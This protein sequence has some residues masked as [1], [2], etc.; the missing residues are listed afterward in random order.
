WKHAHL[1]PFPNVGELAR[2]RVPAS[3]IE[4][5]KRLKSLRGRLERARRGAEN[6]AD[7]DLSVPLLPLTQLRE[8]KPRLVVRS[9]GQFRSSFWLWT[10]PFFAAFAAVHAVWR[11]R[12]LARARA[13]L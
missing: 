6:E 9:P 12:R 2:M 4:R 1:R 7:E 8:V 5:D 3:Q 11:T 13:D 10:V